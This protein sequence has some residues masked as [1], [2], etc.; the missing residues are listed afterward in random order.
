MSSKVIFWN[1]INQGHRVC[2]WDPKMF[3]RISNFEDTL[4]LLVVQSSKN[5]PIEPHV[6]FKRYLH[7]QFPYNTCGNLKCV[8]KSF[9]KYKYTSLKI[10]DIWKFWC[11]LQLQKYD[12]LY[13]VKNELGFRSST[14]V[15]Q[16][17]VFQFFLFYTKL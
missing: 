9:T 11:S 17:L 15:F 7:R 14:L 5:K 8:Y 12:R 1:S 6:N 13:S 10:S 2:C 16:T 4:D 3:S